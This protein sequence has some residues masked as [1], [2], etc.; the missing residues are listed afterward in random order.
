MSGLSLT[1]SQVQY[2]QSYSTHAIVNSQKNLI[3]SIFPAGLNKNRTNK[4]T[5]EQVDETSKIDG[6]NDCDEGFATIESTTFSDSHGSAHTGTSDAENL[7]LVY[8]LTRD[9]V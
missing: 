4:D 2:K 1:H 5:H 3:Q 6:F 9:S 8:K 7:W